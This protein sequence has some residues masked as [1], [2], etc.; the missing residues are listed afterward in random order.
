MCAIN[1]NRRSTMSEPLNTRSKIL[2]IRPNSRGLIF[3]DIETHRSKPSNFTS[4][5]WSQLKR[6]SKDEQRSRIQQTEDRKINNRFCT[7]WKTVPTLFSNK[8][9]N[10]SELHNIQGSHNRIVRNVMMLSFFAE[11]SM[12]N[13]INSI[14][15]LHCFKKVLDLKVNYDKSNLFG[16]DINV[17]SL[18]SMA[19]G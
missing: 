3:V 13:L 2:K 1:V 9:G 17:E 4:V 6:I 12:S 19:T 14:S 7:K 18:T 11:W 10:G 16:L 8:P 15:I 5:L